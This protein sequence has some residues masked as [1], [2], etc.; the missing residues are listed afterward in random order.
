MTHRLIQV[1]QTAKKKV[2]CM[3]TATLRILDCD[4]TYLLK[5]TEDAA[6]R[7]AVGIH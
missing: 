6:V 7:V 5:A 4:S 3:L 2:S 1:V